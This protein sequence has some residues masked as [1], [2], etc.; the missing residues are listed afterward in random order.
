MCYFH[1]NQ[2]YGLGYGVCLNESEALIEANLFNWN[3]HAI[4]ATGA[5]GTRYEARYNVVLDWSN[6][7]SFD[8]H[9]GIDRGDGTEIAGKWVKIHHNT[10]RSQ[11]NA[12]VIRG[13]PTEAAEIHHNWFI[14]GRHV[15]DTVRFWLKSVPDNATISDNLLGRSR[16][17]VP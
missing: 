17:R 5:P 4:A 12:V 9:G 8:M 14:R 15:S 2:R 1:H 16:K 13:R 6:N 3:R 7:H 10:F 11:D